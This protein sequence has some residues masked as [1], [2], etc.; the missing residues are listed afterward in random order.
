MQVCA[1]RHTSGCAGAVFLLSGA[2]ARPALAANNPVPFVHIVSPVNITPGATGVTLMVRETEFVATST[3]VWN[4][5][6]LTETTMAETGWTC[7]ISSSSCAK[8]LGDQNWKP[9]LGPSA[10]GSNVR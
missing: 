6:S 1:I 8:S 5:T 9:N 7:I 3:V 10:F 2:P 4:A